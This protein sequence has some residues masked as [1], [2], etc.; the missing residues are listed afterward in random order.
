M[1]F[2]A[3]IMVHERGSSRLSDCAQTRHMMRS[4]AD[5]K[6]RHAIKPGT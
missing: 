6:Q 3:A 4:A 2:D 1:V 5:I